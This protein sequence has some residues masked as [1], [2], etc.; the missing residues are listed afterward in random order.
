M[1]VGWLGKSKNG[2]AFGGEGIERIV[3][4]T[5]RY[6]RGNLSGFP[7]TNMMVL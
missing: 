1:W 5:L 4:I 3:V 7:A 6:V 2:L